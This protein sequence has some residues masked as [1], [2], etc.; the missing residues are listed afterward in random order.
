MLRA[1]DAND[2]FEERLVAEVF[3]EFSSNAV[4]SVTTSQ[5]CGG[6]VSVRHISADDRHGCHIAFRSDLGAS[7]A[8][9]FAISEQLPAIEGIAVSRLKMLSLPR[10]KLPVLRVPAD[11]SELVADVVFHSSN[12]DW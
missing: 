10:R 8:G 9:M 2:V 3:C 1:I 4:T 7:L 11:A 6:K 12:S 5:P